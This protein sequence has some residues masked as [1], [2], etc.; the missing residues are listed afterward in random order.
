[1]VSSA[2]IQAMVETANA[3]TRQGKLTEEMEGLVPMTRIGEWKKQ[4]YKKG[5]FA[6]SISRVTRHAFDR[7]AWVQ[8]GNWIIKHANIRRWK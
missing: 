3:F 1:M 4:A 5:N 8:K 6:W 7:H 2:Q